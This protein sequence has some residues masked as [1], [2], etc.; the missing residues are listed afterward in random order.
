MK[1]FLFSIAIVAIIPYI[2]ATVFVETVNCPQDTMTF[3][4]FSRKSD[5]TVAAKCCSE[6]GQCLEKDFSCPDGFKI[7]FTINGK[8]AVKSCTEVFKNNNNKQD[9]PKKT[10]EMK[11][12]GSNVNSNTPKS[13]A[14]AHVMSARDIMAASTAMVLAFFTL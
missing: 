8:D 5:V 13:N 3:A 10:E 2:R 14:G 6:N 4:T 12:S 11:S 7:N 1:V 9:A